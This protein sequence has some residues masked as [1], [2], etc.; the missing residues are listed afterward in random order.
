MA[1][2]ELTW[3]SPRV[4]WGAI[5]FVLM[6]LWAATGS[7]RE[8]CGSVSEELREENTRLSLWY[9]SGESRGILESQVNRIN[10][11]EKKRDR[12]CQAK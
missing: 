9:L 8:S 6:I 7:L 4:V 2:Q 5:L 3:K 10:E 12:L 11:L 1:K